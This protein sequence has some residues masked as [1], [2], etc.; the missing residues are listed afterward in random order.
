MR[1]GD[2]GLDEIEEESPATVQ[3]AGP[4]SNTLGTQDAGASGHKESVPRDGRT[5]VDDRE[6][7]MPDRSHGSSAA[8]P[9]AQ[10]D[11]LF[12]HGQTPMDR[13]SMPFST[14][15]EVGV[16]P[17]GAPA[18][19]H[20]RM[21]T[22]TPREE[23]GQEG[24]GRAPLRT[25]ADVH[26]P[27][28]FVRK[29]DGSSAVSYADEKAQVDDIKAR[30]MY[31]MIDETTEITGNPT[32][33]VYFQNRQAALFNQA[34][35]K[36]LL[37][38]FELQTPKL[39]IRLSPSLGGSHFIS[40]QSPGVATVDALPE[41][42]FTER[43]KEALLKQR[44]Q[45]PDL[46]GE[47]ANSPYDKFV[48]PSFVS[49]EQSSQAEWKIEM[50]CRDVL[51]PM[52][53]ETNAL[54]IG[55][56][57]SD[58]QLFM[59]FCRQASL[60]KSKYGGQLPFSTLG[61]GDA[62]SFACCIVK[63]GESNVCP[64]FNVCSAW[65]QRLPLILR[66][67]VMDSEDEDAADWT[68]DG[69][70]DFNEWDIPMDINPNIQNFLIVE[71]V[72][73]H[74][75][76][77]VKGISHDH[78]EALFRNI[79]DYLVASLPSVCIGTM[80]N[81]DNVFQGLG[82]KELYDMMEMDIPVLLLD[83]VPKSGDYQSSK[84]EWQEARW[85]L[86]EEAKEVCINR[87]KELQAIGRTD[88]LEGSRLARFH[89]LL[90]QRESGAVGNTQSKGPLWMRI[91][92]K[93]KQNSVA[94]SS[95]DEVKQLAERVA[96]FLVKVEHE[97]FWD[98][99]PMS[100]KEEL[101]K[102]GITS[103]IEYFSSSIQT[104][105]IHYYNILTSKNFHSAHISEIT[106]LK[107]RVNELVRKDRLPQDNSLEELLMLQA[108]WDSVDI[109]NHVVI[110]YK[111]LAKI[112]YILLLLL[113]IFITAITV[114]QDKVNGTIAEGEGG[115]A[116]TTT[117]QPPSETIIFISSVIVSFLTAV[118]AFLNPT[119]RWHQIRESSAQMESAIWQFRTRTGPFTMSRSHASSEIEALKE[120]IM[121]CRSQIMFSA[122]VAETGYWKKYPSNN[123]VHGQYPDRAGLSAKV[124][125]EP[126]PEVG[127][128]ED[129]VSP[130]QPTK[131]IQLR[132]LTLLSFY[133]S[134][135][136]KYDR[137]RNT[138]SGLLLVGTAA[139]AIIAYLGFSKY[140]AILTATTAAVTSWLEFHSTSTKISRYSASILSINNLLLWW[141]SISDVD[142][143][144]PANVDHLVSMGEGIVN[145]ERHAWLSTGH[146]K[147]K[148]DKT[149]ASN[150]EGG[151]ES[152]E[153]LLKGK[154]VGS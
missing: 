89:G 39:V 60:M 26:Q 61:L 3:V 95:L 102:T 11:A 74:K 106:A 47:A 8:K 45:D 68:G 153:L 52:A 22:I 28:S 49:E 29:D 71:C 91:Q 127:G 148:D 139:A 55:S 16:E 108:A 73:V 142:K 110:H 64:L 35:V 111:R 36:N 48:L 94:Q 58:D 151:D 77:E 146:S 100:S 70:K 25:L 118:L 121:E 125:T 18:P 97:A 23:A 105:R 17:G 145:T 120:K 27:S 21:H 114:L 140:V 54:V 65:R 66:A 107:H 137:I 147:D 116:H 46:A 150:R 53:A 136:P 123:F 99:L 14:P 24:L 7:D 119:K 30:T 50:F 56:A 15:S 59:A 72:D 37:G 40:S 88:L 51:V 149:S 143:A 33:L 79:M 44:A 5:P 62:P 78:K 126:D 103:H 115:D 85:E 141:D 131:Y 63:G 101:A 76:G 80:H 90:F 41:A 67:L 98:I 117:R 152:K 87:M 144:S 2:T 82:N 42:T 10:G 112:G 96:D 20:D 92:E 113:G 154:G 31:K 132:L 6:L 19:V 138:C 86:F 75:S 34:N 134:R 69:M 109:G 4:D 84:R 93:Q 124:H 32:K 1:P 122:D 135:I 43:V 9:R 128:I 83:V 13:P 133:Q 104:S 81:N 129:H 130:L 38:A 12:E 57:Y